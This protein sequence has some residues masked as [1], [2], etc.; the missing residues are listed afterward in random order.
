MTRTL[1]GMAF[2]VARIASAEPYDCD[3]TPDPNPGGSVGD[4]IECHRCGGIELCQPDVLWPL[5][6]HYPPLEPAWLA[7]S[8]LLIP[9]DITDLGF[10]VHWPA[11]FPHLP[12][13]TPVQFIIGQD[14]R[15]KP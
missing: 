10:Q 12:F 2:L 4:G 9:V 1:V 8:P 13:G 7:N 5:A 11:G 3:P 14:Q 6:L 15:R